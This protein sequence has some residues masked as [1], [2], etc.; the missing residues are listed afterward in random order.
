MSSVFCAGSYKGDIA[1]TS[2]NSIAKKARVRKSVRKR[3][4]NGAPRLQGQLQVHTQQAVLST[5]IVT[6]TETASPSRSLEQTTLMSI[7]GTS[8][9]SITMPGYPTDFSDAISNMYWEA[10]DSLFSGLLLPDETDE[11][12]GLSENSDTA[13]STESYPSLAP[14]CTG[15]LPSQPRPSLIPSSQMESSASTSRP[16]NI[17]CS[18]SNTLST[19]SENN[20][21]YESPAGQV[22]GSI[23]ID[24]IEEEVIVQ[25]VSQD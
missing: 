25:R 21:L 2:T 9:S 24:K 13:S 5:A 11:T 8:L 7:F 22:A 19:I 18:S 20:I 12:F 16:Q 15:D 6:G 4:Y 17:D 1:W 3:R 14:T 23:S 10:E